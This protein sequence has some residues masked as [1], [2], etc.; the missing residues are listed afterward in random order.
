[1][2]SPENIENILFH[3]NLNNYKSSSSSQQL[4]DCIEIREI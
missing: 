1:M 2:E 4:F 3:Q